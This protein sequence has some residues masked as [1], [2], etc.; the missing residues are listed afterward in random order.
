M[1]FKFVPE[2]YQ[3]DSEDTRKEMRLK[4]KYVK[5]YHEDFVNDLVQQVKDL[6]ESL[7]GAINDSK[8][9]GTQRAAI[10]VIRKAYKT[11]KEFKK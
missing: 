10:P 8:N 2:T 3:E 7:H 11:V 4:L 6:S 1:S 9:R 5:M